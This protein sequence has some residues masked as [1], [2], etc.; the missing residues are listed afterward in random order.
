MQTRRCV[1][2][3]H[4]KLV[5]SVYRNYSVNDSKT[6]H[7]NEFGFPLISRS[8]WFL[9]KPFIGGNE[10]GSV[11]GSVSFRGLFKATTLL[12][13]ALARARVISDSSGHAASTVN[14]CALLRTRI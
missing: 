1:C 5:F 4:L 9:K 2:V 10:A 12:S 11:R 8:R 14:W 7:E 13:L 6:A 3:A